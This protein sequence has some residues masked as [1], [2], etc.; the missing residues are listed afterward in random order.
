MSIERFYT[1]TCVVTRMTWANESS[2]EASVGTFLGHIQQATPEYVQH[3]AEAWG[4]TF[5]IWADKD[6]DVEDGDSIEI[7]S[8]DYAGTY[9]VK[10]IQLNATGNNKHKEIVVIRDIE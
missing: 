8:G 7:E 9:N 2:A 1:T 10:N 6:A 5:I 4:Q 3:I